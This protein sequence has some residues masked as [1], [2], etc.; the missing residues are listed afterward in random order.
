MQPALSAPRSSPAARL[1]CQ[2]RSDAALSNT[3]ALA[4]AATLTKAFATIK[5]ASSGAA[6]ST[7]SEAASSHKYP[8][9]AQELTFSKWIKQVRPS[10]V[11]LCTMC[12]QMLGASMEL[13]CSPLAESSGYSPVATFEVLLQLSACCVP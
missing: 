13:A 9:L 2:V 1:L 7:A 11:Q 12:L 10:H 4:T 3:E 6:A 5:H 8:R